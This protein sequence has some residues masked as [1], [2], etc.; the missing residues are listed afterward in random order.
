MDEDRRPSRHAL[1]AETDDGWHHTADFVS[2][3]LVWTLIGWALDLWLE[4]TPWLVA[5]GGVVGFTLGLY[6]LWLRLTT[7]D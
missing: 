5:L 7:D 1:L 3:V 6:I 4:T 2:A